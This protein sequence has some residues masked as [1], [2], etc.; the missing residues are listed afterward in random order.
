MVEPKKLPDGLAISDMMNG[1][2]K[3][4][5]CE[6]QIYLRPID[7]SAILVF[8]LRKIV[9]RT[10]MG[11]V[12]TGDDMARYGR[13]IYCNYTQL[14]YWG[15]IYEDRTAGGWRATTTGKAFVNDECVMPRRVWVFADEARKMPDEYSVGIIRVGDVKDWHPKSR[16]EARERLIALESE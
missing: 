4:P 9:E 5:T 16:Q 6:Q 15:L 3:C 8:A 14:K 2:A 1:H 7:L 13:S 10:D 11:A 12:T